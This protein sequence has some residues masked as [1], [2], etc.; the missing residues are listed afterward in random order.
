MLPKP[1]RITL[2]GQKLTVGQKQ[3]APLPTP[4]TGSPIAGRIDIRGSIPAL[5]RPHP[6]TPVPARVNL[7]GTGWL[8]LKIGRKKKHPRQ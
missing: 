1:A 5:L 3:G 8:L 2:G 6:M 4:E 7:L